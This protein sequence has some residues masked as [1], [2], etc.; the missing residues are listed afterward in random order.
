[1]F[2]LD[3]FLFVIEHLLFIFLLFLLFLQNLMLALHIGIK[4]V[5]IL[6]DLLLSL[7]ADDSLEACKV[8]LDCLD[9]LEPLLPLAT[10]GGPELIDHLIELLFELVL[11][12]EAAL[13]YFLLQELGVLLEV[14]DDNILEMASLH[15]SMVEQGVVVPSCLIYRIHLARLTSCVQIIFDDTRCSHITIRIRIQ[16][17]RVS[18]R[19]H[20]AVVTSCAKFDFS[21]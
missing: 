18:V 14:F 6:A 16:R 5:Q 11:G 3:L 8:W 12:F 19:R 1:M 20:A 17:H 9:F 7:A 15:A 4:L 2:C 10:L 21:F 13:I